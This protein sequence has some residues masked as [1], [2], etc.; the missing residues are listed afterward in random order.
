MPAYVSY[1]AFAESCLAVFFTAAT[2][3]FMSLLIFHIR[4]RPWKLR[5]GQFSGPM[6]V[7]LG[8]H[9]IGNTAGFI[10]QL[11]RALWWI[12]PPW[13]PQG[14][15][16]YDLY[17][18]YLIGI[19]ALVYTCVGPV[20]VVFLTLDRI[21]ALNHTTCTIYLRKTGKRKKIIKYIIC[22]LR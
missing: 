1:L 9:I 8:T 4:W 5:V 19:P 17:T 3:V 20:P 16:P 13:R 2:V 21:F 18:L 12:P 7:Y 22:M 15:N 11:Y 14:L 6:L 10:Y